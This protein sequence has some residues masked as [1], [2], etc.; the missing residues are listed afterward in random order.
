MCAALHQIGEVWFTNKSPNEPSI[1]YRA[2]LADGH[3]STQVSAVL[4]APY[5]SLGRPLPRTVLNAAKME[6]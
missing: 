6:L 4:S 1:Q 3:H 5:L 2:R